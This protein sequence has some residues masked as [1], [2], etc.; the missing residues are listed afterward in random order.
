MTL[1]KWSDFFKQHPYSSSVLFSLVFV[2]LEKV[3]EFDFV[4]PCESGFTEAFFCCYLLVPMFIA[5]VF[6]LY[7]LSFKRSS[8][9]E[10]G[11]DLLKLLACMVPSV[12]WLAMFLCDGRYTACLYTEFGAEFSDSDNP[13]PWKWC[14]KTQTLTP[15]EIITLVSF[16]I[17]KLV[18]FGVFVLISAVALIYKCCMNYCKC[19]DFTDTEPCCSAHGKTCSVA[20]CRACC[21]H[22]KPNCCSAHRDMRCSAHLP[23]DASSSQGN[24][25]DHSVHLELHSCHG[26]AACHCAKPEN[27]PSLHHHTCR[28]DCHKR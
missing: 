13:S 24:R 9:G 6:G 17:S 26:A 7:L 4:C 21:E 3:V 25:R 27:C 1:S 8:R 19:L 20:H 12:V 14:E 22:H 18:G 11:S 23:E 16:Y 5:F 10:H 2:A 15:D 28:C